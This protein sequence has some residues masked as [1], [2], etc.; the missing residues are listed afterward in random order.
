VAVVSSLTLD[1]SSTAGDAVKFYLDHN[2]NLFYISGENAFY[3]GQTSSSQVSFD[4]MANWVT[5]GVA[6]L[7]QCS[8]AGTPAKL[9]C[10]SNSASFDTWKT[11][12]TDSHVISLATSSTTTIGASTVVD[13]DMLVIA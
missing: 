6:K 9:T 2:N 12:Q 11:G 8:V 10:T 4:S 3:A 13:M 1:T 5:S 7:L